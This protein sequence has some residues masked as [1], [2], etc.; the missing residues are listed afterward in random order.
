M[1]EQTLH[2]KLSAINSLVSKN[3]TYETDIDQYGVI[4]KW[5]MPDAAYTG[6]QRFKGDCEDHAL[7]CRK[8]CREAGLQTR[9][10][11]CLMGDEG[12]CVLEC[13]GWIFCCNQK[14]V[15]T[16]D[17][18]EKESYQFLYISG[19]EPGDPWHEIT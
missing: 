9:L 14:Q 1:N 11:V 16:R 13:E 7:A 3:F 19:Y 6:R 4:E 12:H 10:V 15:K 18:L 5:V 2:Q 17:S 8:L